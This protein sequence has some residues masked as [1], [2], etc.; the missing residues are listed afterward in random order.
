MR[1]RGQ[2]IPRGQ[3][4]FEPREVY[5]ALARGLGNE[6]ARGP[7]VAEL[8]AR[9]KALTGAP[10]ALALPR[11][12]IALHLVLEALELPKGSEVVMSPVTIPDIVNAV[13]IAGLRPVFVDLAER[14]CNVDYEAL[15]S[16]V[17]PRTS[18]ILVTHLCGFPSDMDRIMALARDHAL[19][20]IEDCSQ[21]MGGLWGD[22]APGLS[23][24]VGR[25]VGF[26]GLPAARLLCRARPVH[27][28][29]FER[30][31]LPRDCSWPH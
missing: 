26:R 22:K 18:A 5:G 29:R 15:S 28:T 20:V 9:F 25:P 19:K 21:S 11:T 4:Y 1:G 27:H 30:L 31:A 16:A 14:T 17:S 10:R 12:R 2:K 7:K 6:L 23:G 13:L 24:D 3:L 8:E